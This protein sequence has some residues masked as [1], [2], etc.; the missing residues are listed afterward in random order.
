[1]STMKRQRNYCIAV[2]ASGL[3]LGGS[4]SAFAQAPASAPQRETAR[5]LMDDGERL[6]Q[7]GDLRTALARFQAAHAL[8]HLPTTGLQVAR[9]HKALGEY[10]E[11]RGVAL[12]V[13]HH[14]STAGEPSVFA[15]ARASAAKLAEDLAPLVPSLHVR[16]MPEGIVSVVRVD[17]VVLPD[18]SR[19]H[20]YKTNPGQHEV[21][22]EAQGF[23]AERRVA[24]LSEGQVLQL[25][26]QLTPAAAPPLAGPPPG[27]PLPPQPM[28]P[29]SPQAAALTVRPEVNGPRVDDSAQRTRAYVGFAVGGVALLTGVVTGVLA[30]MKTSQLEDDCTDKRC[31]LSKRDAMSTANTFSNVANVTV[32]LGLVA[33]GYGLYEILTLPDAPDR[34]RS[35][36]LQVQWDGSTASVR[37]SL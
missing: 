32:P 7:A 27:Q 15:E 24:A 31:P 8:V 25:S 17:G 29:V 12:E 21:V 14:P 19:A 13:F 18:A 23:I 26:V 4:V 20:P 22:V 3:W 34:Q 2:L 10:V 11:A 5:G 37:G 33:L 1:M 30:A 36:G 28:S 16:V 35:S 9:V 6:R